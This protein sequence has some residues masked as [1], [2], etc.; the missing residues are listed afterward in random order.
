MEIWWDTAGLLGGICGSAGLIFQ[1]VKGIK[2][3]R[4][5]DISP[6]LLILTIFGCVFWYLYGVHKWDIIIMT[7][8]FFIYSLSFAILFL[9]EYYI[10]HRG[11]E[12][13]KEKG[14]RIDETRVMWGNLPKW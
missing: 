8:N 7:T 10:E 12:K 2:R 9:R 14:G 13:I 4:L 3:K 6:Y 11:E 1:L 5:D